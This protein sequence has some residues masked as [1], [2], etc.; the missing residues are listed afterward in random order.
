MIRSVIGAVIAFAIV[1]LVITRADAEPAAGFDHLGHR[2]RVEVSGQPNPPCLA[3]HPLTPAGML[4]A[5]PDH[6]ACFP[7]HGP[8]PRRGAA[9]LSPPPATCLACHPAASLATRK[10]TLATPI[11]GPE[12]EYGVQLDHARHGDACA[13]CHRTADFAPP[14]PRAH[15]RCVGCH[16]TRAPLMTACEDCH[17]GAV[18]PDTRPHLISAPLSVAAAYSHRRHGDRIGAVVKPAA[19][20]AG[21][22]QAI[23]QTHGGELPTPTAAACSSGGCHDGGAASAITAACTRCHV[24]A[25]PRWPAPPPPIRFSHRDHATL[26]AIDAC[27]AC[28]T[29]DAHGQPTAP[30]HAACS[31]AACHAR[32]FGS[33]TPTTCGAC[34]LA[35]EPWRKMIADQ[36]PPDDNELG[37]ALSHRLHP[38]PCTDCHQ[39][40]TPRHPL[41]PPRGHGA[42]TTSGC[43]AADRG[44]APRLTA[45]A[46]C[47]QPG[48]VDARRRRRS[49]ALWSVAATFDHD[50]H[51]VSPRDGRALACTAC[52]TA[53]ASDGPMPAPTKPTCAPCH[54]GVVAFKMTG[55]GC[56]RCHGGAT[57]EIP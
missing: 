45:C 48:V 8:A 39:L 31:D 18:G 43:H 56:A 9:P 36:R 21:C 25:A 28:H 4:A 41:R 37:V 44:P 30:S 16:L 34:H 40:S 19:T 20:C 38:G 47:H 10:P 52:H 15:A 6:R 5:R 57:P 12:H 27:A 24:T 50:R 33:P 53:A 46:G 29:L 23:T 49:L 7:C 35:R 55:H 54:D 1:A 32:D 11:Y 17:P 51:R 13:S 2:T 14:A 42:C 26:T 3:C 22:H